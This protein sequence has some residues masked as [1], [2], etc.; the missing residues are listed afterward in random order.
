[1]ITALRLRELLEY[2]PETGHFRWRFDRIFGGVVNARAGD[3]AGAN[4]QGYVR[5]RI[6]G[7]NYLAHRLAFLYMTGEWPG[8]LVDHRDRD[9]SNN[10]WSNLRQATTSQNAINSRTRADSVLG[11]KGVH[12]RPNGRYEAYISRNSRRTY[13]GV[14]DTIDEARTARQRAAAMLHGDFQPEAA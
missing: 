2:S 8:H 5:I 9:T 11:V 14:Y 1:M 10:R 4:H 6:A 12:R 7:R 13:L 3:I